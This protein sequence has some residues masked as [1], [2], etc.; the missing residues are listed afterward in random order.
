MEP[1]QAWIERLAELRDAGRP[2]VMV[3]VTDVQGSAP[4]EPG[5]RMLV[6]DGTLSWGTIGGGN[7]EKQAIEHSQAMLGD[8]PDG[9]PCDRRR[10]SKPS[11]RP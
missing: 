2:C 4:R 7:L 5:A 8:G 3:V 6:S 11:P 9:P 10:G 1:N